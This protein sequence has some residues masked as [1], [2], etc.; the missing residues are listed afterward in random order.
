MKH[1]KEELER[2]YTDRDLFAA[3]VVIGCIVM[4]ALLL[5]GAIIVS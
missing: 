5:L 1:T 4:S 3:G 2:G